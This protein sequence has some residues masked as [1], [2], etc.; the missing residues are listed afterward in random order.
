MCGQHKNFSPNLSHK[1][2]RIVGHNQSPQVFLIPELELLNQLR[3]GLQSLNVF[4][5]EL[6][7]RELLVQQL[8]YLDEPGIHI[9]INIPLDLE[10]PTSA[11]GFHL[12]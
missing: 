9:Q 6:A 11:N 2:F 4:R 5:Y 3:P 7:L 12:R 1:E 8:S 10:L